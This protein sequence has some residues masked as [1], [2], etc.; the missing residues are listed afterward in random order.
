MSGS[1]ASTFPK[2]SKP[3]YGGKDA[4][5]AKSLQT[6][7]LAEANR[8][9]RV[10]LAEFERE[11][12][13][14]RAA[15]GGKRDAVVASASGRISAASLNVWQLGHATQIV[16]A[17]FA[18]R[19]SVFQRAHA[20]PKAFWRG[21]I[22]PEPDDWQTLRGQPYSYW[23]HLTEDEATSLETG[24]AY[25]LQIERENRLAHPARLRMRRATSGP[26][27]RGGALLAS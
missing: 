8:L 9:A 11:F 5:P 3:L 1:I 25:A 15:L 27:G 14:K 24:V 6:R 23:A 7:D 20:D 13:Q 21:D 10:R 2:T 26:A 4:L 19:A 18:H 17:D 22:V 16:E 12:A